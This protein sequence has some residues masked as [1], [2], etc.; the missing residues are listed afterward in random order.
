MKNG[1]RIT[2]P[3]RCIHE[4]GS[5]L[6]LPM[7]PLYCSPPQLLYMHLRHDVLMPVSI[8]C[9]CPGVILSILGTFF[10]VPGLFTVIYPMLN[11]KD[12][13]IY[14]SKRGDAGEDL[15]GYCAEENFYMVRNRAA[16]AL[17]RFLCLAHFFSR[18]RALAHEPAHATMMLQMRRWPL[19]RRRR[20]ALPGPSLT[21]TLAMWL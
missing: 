18:P 10:Y 2:P 3:V 8:A 12:K 13:D 16:H 5:P 17:H 7:P 6:V 9:F 15:V 14:Y 20:T 11:R 4:G 21:S 19:A 1:A